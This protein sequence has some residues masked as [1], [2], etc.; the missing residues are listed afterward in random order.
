MIERILFKN[1]SDEDVQR[2][3]YVICR[4][5][6]IPDMV[7]M[8]MSPEFAKKHSCVAMYFPGRR[9]GFSNITEMLH[10]GD[11]ITACHELAHHVQKHLYPES[12]FETC[13]G[14]TFG[15]ACGRIATAIK[16]KF[17][18]QAFPHDPSILRRIGH[19]GTKCDRAY[20]TKVLGYKG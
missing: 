2:V 13:H 3:I 16:K 15:L 6:G 14:K 4:C 10:E 12:N 18:K 19:G 1:F 11:M 9:N 5:L 20:D 17:G 8:P 7:I